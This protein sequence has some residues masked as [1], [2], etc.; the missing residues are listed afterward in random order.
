MSSLH[1]VHYTKRSGVSNTKFYLCY[2][3]CGDISGRKAYSVRGLVC[4]YA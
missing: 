1:E 4:W 3:E 2:G